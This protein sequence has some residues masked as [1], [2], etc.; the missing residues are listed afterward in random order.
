VVEPLQACPA[1]V[2][3]DAWTTP[4]TPTVA[5]ADFVQSPPQQARSFVQASP[6]WVQNDT[7]MSHFPFVHNPEQQSPL[8]LQVLPAVLHEVLSGAQVPPEQAPPQHSPSEVQAFPSEMH[9]EALH[10][11]F[12]QLNVQ[13][14][15]PA[16][17]VAPAA[18]QPVMAVQ[19]C[20]LASQLPEQQS[21]AA[22]HDVPAGKHP[23]KPPPAPPVLPPVPVPEASLPDDPDT[24]A[25]PEAP[26]VPPPPFGPPAGTS[27]ELPH[28]TQYSTPQ[29]ANADHKSFALSS[30]PRMIELLFLLLGNGK[31][32]RTD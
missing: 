10:D 15:G 12:T 7:A 19:R 5:V 31:A 29:A 23:G 21:P 2:Q 11:P 16:E 8:A 27:P 22:V 3:L 25:S 30:S 14:S 17:H 20:V 13:Q 4:Q 1:G 26:L 6:F 9:A 32:A 18:W 24:E 28:A